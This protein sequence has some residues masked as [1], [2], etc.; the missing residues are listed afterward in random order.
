MGNDFGGLGGCEKRDEAAVAVEAEV[1][2]IGDNVDRCVPGGER[3]RGRTG[4]SIIYGADVETRK[5]DARAGTVD[6]GVGRMGASQ[7]DCQSV[8][9]GRRSVEAGRGG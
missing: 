4:A 3:R 1:A 9:R 6:G 8:E 5:A 7:G 2:V